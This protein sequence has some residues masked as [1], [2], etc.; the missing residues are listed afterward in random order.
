MISS[1][2]QNPSQRVNRPVKQA[3]G[4]PH[5]AGPL[6]HT[7]GLFLAGMLALPGSGAMAAAGGVAAQTTGPLRYSPEQTRASLERIL[8]QPEYNHPLAKLFL[9]LDDFLRLLQGALDRLMAFLNGLYV[10]SPI[11]YSLV[12][13]ASLMLLLLILG[14]IGFVLHRSLR[15]D[16][17]G[18]EDAPEQDLQRETT[19]SLAARAEALA[20][21]GAYVDAIRLL[22]RSL[23][24][25]FR[26]QDKTGSIDTETNREFAMRW[27]RDPI[28]YER[29]LVLVRFLD[30]KWY[31]MQPCS[32]EDYRLSRTVY[33]ELMKGLQG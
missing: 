19:A 4:K 9:K 6:L 3:D 2:W 22:F 20:A 1:S 14:H 15:G 27:H 10:T 5:S 11:L 29:L 24:A 31:G 25:E 18:G 8:A 33:D 17:A 28:R 21:R 13:F 7:G 23:V 26:R 32:D 30:E 12:M 16:T